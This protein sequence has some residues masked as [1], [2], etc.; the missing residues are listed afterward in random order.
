[1]FPRILTCIAHD[2]NWSV[3]GLAVLVCCISSYTV[4]LLV[5]HFLKATSGPVRRNWLLAAAG[6]AGSAMWV[7]HFLSMLA[8]APAVRASYDVGIATLSLAVGV[9]LSVVALHAGRSNG[10]AATARGGLALAGAVIV[11]HHI[12]MQGFRPAAIVLIDWRYF[13][14]AACGSLLPAVATLHLAKRAGAAS[15]L[16]ATLSLIATIAVV[17]FVSMAGMSL[18]PIADALPNASAHGRDLLAFELATVSLLIVAGA[19]LTLSF[20]ARARRHR[21]E[22]LRARSLADASIDGLAIFGSSGVIAANRQ[23]LSLTGIADIALSDARPQD[24]FASPDVLRRLEL[25]AGEV[26]EIE[27]LRGT[28]P[29]P[30]EASLHAVTIA[31]VSATAIALRDLRRSKAAEAEIRRLADLDPLTSLPN[32]R[33]F[34]REL[35]SA[36]LRNDETDAMVAVLCLDLDRLKQ[37][38]DLLGHFAG[39]RMIER[40]AAILRATIPETAFAARLGGDEFAVA[41]PCLHGPEDA[42]AAATAIHDALDAEN[43]S[44][45]HDFELSASIGIAI[46]PIHGRDKQSLLTAA[47]IALYRAKAQQRGTSCLFEPEMG[48]E[49]IERRQAEHDLK[50]AVEMGQLSLV[51][52]P[53]FAAQDGAVSGYEALVRWYRPGFGNVPPDIFIPLAERCGAI[54]E[55][56][57][58]VLSTACADAARWDDETS[59][60]VNVSAV[61]ISSAGFVRKVH[62]TLLET[63]LSPHRL[64]LEVTETSLV[65]DFEAALLTLRQLKAMGVSIVMDDFGTGYSSLAHLQAFPFDK[66]KIDRSFVRQLGSDP[67]AATI[68]RAVLDLGKG[69]GVPVLAEGVETRSELEFLQA[70]H[71]DEV[72]GF[73]VGRP[74]DRPQAARHAPDQQRRRAAGA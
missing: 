71:C 2:H 28:E 18:I 67:K 69:L 29:I 10:S 15:Q 68:V 58:W 5:R 43:K 24:L 17:H 52:Q 57:E 48:R 4:V 27:I 31:G 73:L 39:D 55:I 12:G 66:I 30:V 26:I 34:Y 6:A 23:F 54:L 20:E 36:L 37:V 35:K 74:A 56:G 22:M 61:Q 9:M 32:R 11:M 16:A 1:M 59:V 72:Q 13:V 44:A 19:L 41:I 49:L 70:A 38:N 60:A 42:V 63:G 46:S 25:A 8:F 40:F 21:D 50:Q 51:Y 3:L 62:E 53:Q 65:R 64:H 14:L 33:R 47:D 45:G 7:T